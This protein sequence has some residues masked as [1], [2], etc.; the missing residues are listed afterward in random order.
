MSSVHDEHREHAPAPRWLSES[1]Q[2]SWR[3]YLKGT[4]LV[5]E[6]LDRDLQAH[7]MQLTEYEILSMISESPGHRLR[8]S[9]I[10]EM[11]V[12][13]RS[14]L[15]H[16]AS[17][18]EKRGWVTRQSCLQDRR[19]VELVLTDAGFAQ[20]EAAAPEH[21]ASVRR[22]LVDT[23]TPAQFEAVGEAMQ[24]VADAGLEP[25]QAQVRSECA[26]AEAGLPA[27]AG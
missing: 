17:R 3:A 13:S 16:T 20:I 4:R 12:Q 22:H 2:A 5:E 15:T 11:V 18:L 19:G 10:A 14:R 9:E 21:L 25:H 23:L 26:A 7:G 24:R 1:E 6:A 8:M 27:T